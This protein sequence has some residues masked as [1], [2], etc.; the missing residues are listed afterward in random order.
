M[1]FHTRT[2]TTSVIRKS[3]IRLRTRLL[4]SVFYVANGFRV[5]FVLYVKIGPCFYMQF[6]VLVLMML[7]VFVIVEYEISYFFTVIQFNCRLSQITR[8]LGIGCA[9]FLLGT[10]FGGNVSIFRSNKPQPCVSQTGAT[11]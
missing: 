5:I 7:V 8:F 10:F 4:N 1:T 9:F 2:K 3:T 6:F 11:K